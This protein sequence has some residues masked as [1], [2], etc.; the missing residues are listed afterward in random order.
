ME[1]EA[2][3][4]YM[5]NVD[6]LEEVLSVKFM[7]DNALESN[8][9]STGNSEI[10]IPGLKLHIRSNPTRS[11]SMRKR[12]QQ[13]VD[14]GLKKLQNCALEGHKEEPNKAS[15]RPRI[16][17]TEWLS[18]ISDLID[19]INKA[20]N[21]EDLKFCLE[22]KSQLFNLDKISSKTEIEDNETLKVQAAE[23]ELAAAKEVDYSFP[24]PVGVAGIDQETLNTIDKH[25]CSL[26]HVEKL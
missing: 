15:K 5:E 1:N 21:E 24:K 16:L 23:S 7:E 26:E 8:P 18:A 20:R 2:F 4:R 22:I 19:K 9:K 14:E 3:D 12:I 10:M 25:F 17:R 6:L 11:D 13:I